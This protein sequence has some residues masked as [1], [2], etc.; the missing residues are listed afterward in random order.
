MENVNDKYFDGEYKDLW[1]AFI[2]DELTVKEVEFIY[3]YFALE[4]GKKVLDLMCGYGRHAIAL[5]KRKINV[6]AVDNLEAYIDEIKKEAKESDLPINALTA[7]V[8]EYHDQ[9]N[10]YDLVLCMGNSF[11]FFE[12]VDANKVLASIHSQLTKGG[13]L[14]INSWSIAEIAIRQ[15]QEKTWN[16]VND[17]K[18][19]IQSQYLFNPTRI[20][21]EHLILSNNGDQEIKVG[22]DYIY[23]LS[24]MERMIRDAGFLLKEV[25]SIPGKKKFRMGDPRAYFVA[26]KP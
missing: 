5:A 3:T 16:T 26:S 9:D 11:N 1:K 25:F 20:E 22:I 2:P 17:K 19:I 10:Y 4:P 23:S 14:L 12:P 6:T 13:N 7:N 15:F 18:Y 8:K 21:F 24:E